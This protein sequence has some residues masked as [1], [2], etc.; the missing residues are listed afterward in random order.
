MFKELASCVARDAI[1][2]SNTSSL[3]ITDIASGI[4]QPDRVIGMHFFNP[5]EKMPLVEIV[6]G[7]DSSERAIAYTAAY[8]AALGK[9]PVVVEDVP[10]FLVNRVLSPYIAE[11]GTLLTEGIE[12]AQI[13][14]AALRFGMPMG[15]IRLLDE[16]GIDIACKVQEMMIAGY[17][18]RMQ[19]PDFLKQMVETKRLGKKVGR[20]FYSYQSDEE[21][22]PEVYDL[23][24]VKPKDSSSN[25]S[26]EKRLM[27]SLVNEAVRAFDEQ[28]A[29][30]PGE[31]A[32]GQVDLATVMGMGFAPFSWW[33]TSLCRRAWGCNCSKGFGITC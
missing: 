3:S 12:I 14:K 10:G 29:G 28:V 11:A 1:L 30:L 20:G 24:G 8:T 15:P 5:A 22:D 18:E 16:V 13:D 23:I 2:A 7:R 32:A 26:V 17:G 27:L 9:F 25:G 21:V 4:P 6:R 19:G 31:E 33:G